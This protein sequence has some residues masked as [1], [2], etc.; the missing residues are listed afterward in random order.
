MTTAVRRLTGWGRTAPTVATVVPGG[1]VG[2][3]VE[4]V[5]H[6]GRR[7]VIA[8]GLSRRPAARRRT[9][10]AWSST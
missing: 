1:G 8:R 3:I 5:R 6:P 9:P 4:A 10:A 7:G 2:G